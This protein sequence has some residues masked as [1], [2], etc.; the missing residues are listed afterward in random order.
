MP[1]R[2]TFRLY[3]NCHHCLQTG[4][5]LLSRKACV[6]G[7]SWTMRR[8]PLFPEQVGSLCQT[9]CMFTMWGSGV[10]YTQRNHRTLNLQWAFLWLHFMYPYNSLLE[11]QRSTSSVTHWE[12]SGSLRMVAKN[13]IPL[14]YWDYEWITPH[15]A[16][17]G[18]TQD[19][20]LTRQAPD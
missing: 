11:E 16:F 18:K 12:N 10:I 9:W 3:I 19:F 17:V 20:M 13:F 4:P 8:L 15:L 14:P 6:L 5:L 2:L 7:R 1:L